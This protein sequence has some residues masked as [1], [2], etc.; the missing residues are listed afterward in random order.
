MIHLMKNP[1]NGSFEGISEATLLLVPG[2]Q[3][4]FQTYEDT[5][6]AAMQEQSLPTVPVPIR[7]M[8]MFYNSVL[9][10]PNCI[11]CE[12]NFPM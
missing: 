6:Q 3:G 1:Q 5:V 12:M 2:Q 4:N 7:Y 10:Q 8:E 9:N 11:K